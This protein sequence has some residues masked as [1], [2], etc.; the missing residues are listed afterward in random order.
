MP[1][2]DIYYDNYSNDKCMSAI[3]PKKERTNGA[4]QNKRNC[5]VHITSV[6]LYLTKITALIVALSSHVIA[7]I[8]LQI[9]KL[10]RS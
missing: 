3:K 4:V 6:F 9:R 1:L 7:E 10:E 8:P 2:K 5:Q